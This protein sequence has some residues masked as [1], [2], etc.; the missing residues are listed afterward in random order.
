ENENTTNSENSQDTGNEGNGGA[1]SGGS[2]IITNNNSQGSTSIVDGNTN[3]ND[4]NTTNDNDNDNEQIVDGNSPTIQAPT[5][6]IENFEVD[7]IGLI[8]KITIEDEEELLTD[9][10]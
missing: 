4:G 10:T 8:A 6:K 5:F 2:S 7:A 3:N 1:G 9:N